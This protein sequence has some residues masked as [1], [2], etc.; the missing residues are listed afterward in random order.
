MTVPAGGTTVT[1]V[2]GNTY[3]AVQIGDQWWMAG[4][5]KVTRY[6][7]GDAIPNVIGESE[8]DTLTTG[9]Y[10]DYDNEVNNV[11]TYGR[12]YNWYAAN[13]SRH[14]APEGWHVPSDAEWQE[15]VNYLGGDATASGKMKEMGTSH[16][17]IPNVDATNES[18]F[19]ALPGGYRLNR[20]GRFGYMGLSA[21]FWS[22]TKDGKSPAWGR[23][24]YYSHSQVDRFNYIKQYGFSVCCVKD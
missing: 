21:N 18:G 9:A 7:N 2:D 3:Q 8:W 1:D 23:S 17:H 11:A 10:C 24:L 22:S 4:N 20:D 13:D 12:L 15:L 19:S 16:W 5:L 6:C 14:L